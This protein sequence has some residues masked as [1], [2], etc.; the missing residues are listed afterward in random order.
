VAAESDEKN[1]G[2][3][4]P[5]RVPVTLKELAATFNSLGSIPAELEKKPEAKAKGKKKSVPNVGQL[6]LSDE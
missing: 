3:T 6:D 1:T 4:K 5:V 2:K